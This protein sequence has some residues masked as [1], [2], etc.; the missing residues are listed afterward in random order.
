VAG[1]K[2]QRNHGPGGGR[3]WLKLPL[4]GAETEYGEA[5]TKRQS[6]GQIIDK[7]SP[8]KSDAGQ[9]LHRRMA[10]SVSQQ[11]CCPEAAPGNY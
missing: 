5:L 6:A 10:R 2:R 1:S 11:S 7:Q 4:A 3:I 8:A 9:A